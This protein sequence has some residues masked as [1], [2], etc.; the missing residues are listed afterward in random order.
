[1]FCNFFYFKCTS[2]LCNFPL[3]LGQTASVFFVMA[4]TLERFLYVKF[5]IK[6]RSWCSWGKARRVAVGIFIFSILYNIP[7]WWEYSS[8]CVWWPDDQEFIYRIRFRLRNNPTYALLYINFMFLIF[9]Q[10][11][12]FTTISILNLIIYR[13]VGVCVHA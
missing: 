2:F 6:S 11:I 3:G 9:I 8:Q 1:M 12:P 7:R 13:E 4:V 5:P 10:I